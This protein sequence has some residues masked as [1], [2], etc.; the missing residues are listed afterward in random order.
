VIREHE[1]STSAG[2]HRVAAGAVHRDP[3]QPRVRAAVDRVVRAALA[4]R[5]LSAPQ[6][7]RGRA[8][9]PVRNPVPGRVL[10][11]R[12]VRPHPARHRP[13]SLARVRTGDRARLR[14]DQAR[15]GA[16]ELQLLHR[17]AGVRVHRPGGAPRS[18]D[19][20]RLLADY[21][22]DPATGLWRHR[23]A[24]PSRRCG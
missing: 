19:G 1:D 3:G 23:P 2:R 10:V 18:P 13:G 9:R 21:R 5:A 17:S 15:L 7:R 6:L 8:Q 11:C 22:F 20:W 24:R 12:A 4:E 16:S 14:G